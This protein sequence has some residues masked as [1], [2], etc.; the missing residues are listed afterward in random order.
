MDVMSMSIQW[1]ASFRCDAVRCCAMHTMRCYA[2]LCDAIRCLITVLL[3]HDVG[4]IFNDVLPSV[5]LPAR[6]FAF[7]LQVPINED[8]DRC[9]HLGTL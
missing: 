4:G 5:A 7:M 2:V 1:A 8:C 3:G 9:T 6:A